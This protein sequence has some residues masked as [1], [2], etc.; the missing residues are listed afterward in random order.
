MVYT[1]KYAGPLQ[2][3]KRSAY[4][5]S[6][7]RNAYPKYRRKAPPRLRSGKGAYRRSAAASAKLRSF[8]ETKLSPLRDINNQAPIRMNPL[9]GPSPVYGTRFLIGNPL[10]QYPNYTALQGMNWPTGTAA[11]QRI[12]NYMYLKKVNLTMEIN[13]NQVGQT[14][15]GPRRFRVIIFKARRYA[16]PTGTTLDPDKGL[17]LDT[18]GLQ[19]GVSSATKAMLDFTHQLSNKRDFQI[20]RDNSFILQ[21]PVG[22][23]SASVDPFISTSGQYKATKTIRCSLPLWRKTKF[24]NNTNLPTDV[25][26]N[27]GIYV[28]SLNVGSSTAIPDDWN[29]SVR[30]VVSANDV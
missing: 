16:N 4:V 18:A 11:D 5:P 14:N 6:S 28:Q 10:T 8:G 22:N 29:I 9:G 3:G 23:P 19:F 7:R 27:Y 1:R 15:S 2:P 21:N 26:Y 30:G 13:M 24:E 25:N 12:G 17:L 20:L